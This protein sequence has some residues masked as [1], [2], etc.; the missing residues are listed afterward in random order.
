MGDGWDL[1]MKHDHV[2]FQSPDWK[3]F[4]FP[5]FGLVLWLGW[6]GQ[7]KSLKFNSIRKNPERYIK[8]LSILSSKH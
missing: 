2:C 7:I 5:W 1:A 6:W 4:C 8:V 3:G